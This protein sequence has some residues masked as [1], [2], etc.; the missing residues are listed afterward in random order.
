[1]R[2]SGVSVESQGD[3][4]PRGEKTPFGNLDDVTFGTGHRG[5][6]CFSKFF[7]P[8]RSS[9]AVHRPHKMFFEKNKRTLNIGL[10]YT[11][12]L[13][14]QLVLFEEYTSGHPQLKKI[15][16]RKVGSD[17]HEQQENWVKKHSSIVGPTLNPAQ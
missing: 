5:G 15:M 17:R 13:I 6:T 11:W 16:L 8:L 10:S 4:C 1:M 2:P 12:Y 7:F 3:D 9:T 14:Y